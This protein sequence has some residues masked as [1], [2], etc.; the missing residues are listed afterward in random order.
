L[1]LETHQ[2]GMASR[3]AL[4]IIYQSAP[5]TSMLA[6]DAF[7]LFAWL[8]ALL[9]PLTLHAQAQ[10]GREGGLLMHDIHRGNCRDKSHWAPG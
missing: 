10:G 2:P 5:S 4:Q 6:G 3:K 8:T 7:W 9:V 1:W